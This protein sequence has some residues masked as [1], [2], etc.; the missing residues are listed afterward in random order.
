MEEKTTAPAKKESNLNLILVP[1]LVLLLISGIAAL[2]LGLVNDVTKPVIAEREKEETAAAMR[3]V[4][5]EAAEFSEEKTAEDG[6]VYYEAYAADGSLCGCIFTTTG[7][8]YGGEIG[9]MT[10]VDA[11]GK[12]TGI[13][14]LS[15]N[16]T[17]GMGMKAQ[18]D[19]FKNQYIGRSG[20]IGV[21]KA[22]ATDT[23]IQA[24]TGATITSKAVTG[25][26]NAALR[27]FEQISGEAK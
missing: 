1:A 24:I 10:G 13:A 20:E 2:L 18:N 9:V 8:G 16:E 19:D 15:I 22:A 6:T 11:E 3:A 4:M 25:A 5:A 14:F 7:S 23:E 26:V 17:P 21:N 27:C 12:V